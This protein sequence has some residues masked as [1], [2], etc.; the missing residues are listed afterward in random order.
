MLKPCLHA[1]EEIPLKGLSG[2]ALRAEIERGILAK[3]RA[4]AL[5]EGASRSRRGMNAIGG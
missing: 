2:E 3:P 5:C 4:H 1:S